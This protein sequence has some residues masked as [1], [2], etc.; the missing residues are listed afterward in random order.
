MATPGNSTAWK[1]AL[2]ETLK[3]RNIATC[4]WFALSSKS[5]TM[6]VCVCNAI[7][8]NELRDAARAGARTPETAYEALGHE[9]HCRSCLCYAQDLID[10]ELKKRP[11]LRIVAA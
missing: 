6:I 3:G 11:R 5:M 1:Q 8:E 4:K 10:E 2:A 7:T 9:P